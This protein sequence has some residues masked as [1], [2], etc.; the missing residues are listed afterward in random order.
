MIHGDTFRQQGVQE[1]EYLRERK[2]IPFN[3]SNH[4]DDSVRRLE[5]FLIHIK[6]PLFHVRRIIPLL[7]RLQTLELKV[8]DEI[9]AHENAQI[10]YLE[11]AYKKELP[12]KKAEVKLTLDT[13]LVFLR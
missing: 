1:Q 4:L 6:H 11:N 13:L 5:F 7:D 2:M 3:L 9:Y 10:E 8:E 12:Q